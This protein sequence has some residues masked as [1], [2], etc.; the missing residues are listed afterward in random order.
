[1]LYLSNY[2]PRQH[3]LFGLDVDAVVDRLAG[4]IAHVFPRFQREHIQEAWVSRDSVAQPVIET[5]YQRRK[6]AYAS[7]IP[8][9]YI[10]NTSQIYPQDRGT[11]YN[12]KIAR[13]CATQ[14]VGDRVAL[15]GG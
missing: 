4:S 11:N 1:M 12:V 8:G 3:E 9:F 2:L 10:C 14:L 15:V 13:E 5:G 6:P 7:P